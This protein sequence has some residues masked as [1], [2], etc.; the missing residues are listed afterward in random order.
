MNLHKYVPHY[1]DVS[2]RALISVTVKGIVQKNNA[3]TILN[4]E[5]NELI[6]LP[7]SILNNDP[8]RFQIVCPY[9]LVILRGNVTIHLT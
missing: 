4:P 9:M 5:I 3:E 6:K 1:I 7:S 2:Q 8:I